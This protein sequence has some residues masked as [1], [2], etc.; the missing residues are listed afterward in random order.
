MIRI[1][2]ILTCLALGL[3]AI[4]A[5]QDIVIKDEPVSGLGRSPSPPGARVYFRELKD[6]DVVDRS[7]RIAFGIDGMKV[8]P[9]G[10]ELEYSGHHHLLIDE[11]ELPPLDLPL[12]KT[13]GIY[14]FGKGEKFAVMSLPPGEHTLQLIF[15][16]Y[17]HVP[18]DPPVMSEKIT[19]IVEE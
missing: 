12:P 1:R 14:H 8:R 3:P 6:G 13:E 18:H 10:T 2:T 16:D 19:I 15:A 7:V 4:A 9:A 17:R 11:E 5:G